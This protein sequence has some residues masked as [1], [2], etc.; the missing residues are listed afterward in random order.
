[1]ADLAHVARSLLAYTIW[2]DRE[3]LEALAK[4]PPEHLAVA[5]GTSFG[6]LLGTIAHVLITEQVWLARFLGAPPP[7]FPD[8]GSFGDLASVREGFEELW[9]QLEF[10]LA[11]LTQEQ[12]GAEIS[13]ISRA[14]DSYRRPVWEALVHMSHH[15]A[16]HRGQLTTMLRQ[17]GH[18]PA[19]TDLIVWFATR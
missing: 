16:Y 6:S 14:G 1:M 13:W 18:E 12:L 9:P 3:Q 8:E 5:T 11:S 15:S 19:P 10:F 2:A 7:D 4:V 17:L